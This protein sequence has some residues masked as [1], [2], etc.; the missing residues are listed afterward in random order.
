MPCES[1]FAASRSVSNARPACH[2]ERQAAATRALRKA[3][4]TD[5]AMRSATAHLLGAAAAQPYTNEQLDGL[6]MGTAASKPDGPFLFGYARV[7]A[8]HERVTRE[9]E[10]LK[11]QGARGLRYYEKLLTVV[12]KGHADW[13][14]KLRVL[15]GVLPLLRSA[16]W[17][18]ERTSVEAELRILSK[19]VLRHEELL[20]LANSEWTTSHPVQR[21]RGY[22]PW[23]CPPLLT[24]QPPAGSPIGADAPAGGPP[25]DEPFYVESEDEAEIS[26]PEYAGEYAEGED[27]G[28]GEEDGGP[29]DDS[30]PEVVEV[31]AELEERAFLRGG[32]YRSRDEMPPPRPEDPRVFDAYLEGMG[33]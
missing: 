22:G 13:E 3:I 14:R 17:A 8:E 11:E 20:R 26:V 6:E 29:E 32:G 12:K 15:D 27:G 24:Q 4:Q 5:F 19:E 33:P 21:R 16:A 7:R 18:V 10:L 9:L 31:G 2:S 25:A 28:G 23:R 1:F 30:G